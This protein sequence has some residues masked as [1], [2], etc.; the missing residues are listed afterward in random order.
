MILVR[1]STRLYVM[2][3]SWTLQEQQLCWLQLRE[4]VRSSVKTLMIKLKLIADDCPSLWSIGSWSSALEIV[5]C[6]EEVPSSSGLIQQLQLNPLRSAWLQT[7]KE[8]RSKSAAVEPSKVRVE[9][10]EDYQD[11]F[12]AYLRINSAFSLL[13]LLSITLSFSAAKMQT[14]AAT[15]AVKE[16]RN[17]QWIQTNRFPLCFEP[18]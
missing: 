7:M 13:V 6:S 16:W 5:V 15:M 10:W 4:L 8:E 2:T 18:S 1:L 17:S 3:E 14:A 12:L 9:S 11:S